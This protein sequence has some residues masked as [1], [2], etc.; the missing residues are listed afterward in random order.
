MGKTA[1]L[2]CSAHLAHS[3]IPVR[4]PPYPHCTVVVFHLVTPKTSSMCPFIWYELHPKMKSR[5][6]HAFFGLIL[7]SILWL[8]EEEKNT[9]WRSWYWRLTE[10]RDGTSHTLD[11]GCLTTSLCKLVWPVCLCV[12]SSFMGTTHRGPTHFTAS[13][14]W[15]VLGTLSQCPTQRSLVPLQWMES[16]RAGPASNLDTVSALLLLLPC[17]L[18]P[19]GAERREREREPRDGCLWSGWAVFAKVG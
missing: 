17:H 6:G 11:I 2:A 16:G 14:M 18:I 9:L 13:W 1:A 10:W 5:H 19:R 4:H 7:G 15:V 8:K 12:D 3:S